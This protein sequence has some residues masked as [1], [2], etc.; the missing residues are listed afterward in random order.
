MIRNPNTGRY[1]QSGGA[2]HRK[3]M[4]EQ[5]GQQYGGL[6]LFGKKPQQF[7]GPMPMSKELS[8]LLIKTNSIRN[9]LDFGDAQGNNN[10]KKL[11]AQLEKVEQM[12]RDIQAQYS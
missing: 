9:I 6:N 7:Q 1:I 3:L 11:V 4:Q 10:Y 2:T 5:Y 8:E 12:I